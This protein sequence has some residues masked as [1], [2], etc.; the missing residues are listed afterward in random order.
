M[1]NKSKQKVIMPHQ[2]PKVR[3]K[4]FKE[5]C[6]GY[7]YE[8]AK[9]EAD[10]CLNCKHKPCV[11]GC[12]VNVDIPE[13]I[14]CI[15]DDDLEKAYKI[16][17][18]TN[19][20]PAICGRVCPQEKQCEA[21]C[22]MGKIGEPVSIG[23]LERYVSDY[24]RINDTKG[25]KTGDKNGIKIAIVGSGP[26]G[27][28]CAN[29]L[30]LL[31]YDVTIYEALHT[32]GGVLS[33]GIP[34]FRLPRDV[35]K[36]EIDKLKLQGVKIETNVVIGKTLSLDDLFE[37][38]YKAVY[39]A[40]GAGIPRFMG[41]PGE[42]LPQVYCANEFLTRINLMNAHVEK[43]DTP[44]FNAKNVLVVGGGNVA[45][46]AARCA[47]RLGAD[48]TV[49]YRRSEEE[50]PARREEV[51][52]AKEEGINFEFLSNPVK[53]CGDEENNVNSVEYVEMK[54]LDDDGTGRRAVAEKGNGV[55]N[56]KAD[57]VI[58]AI[59]NMPNSIIRESD[60]SIKC[61]SNGC[62]VVDDNTLKTSKPNTYA[63]GDAV[64]GAATVIL[65]MNAGKRAALQIDKDI[66]I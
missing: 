66:N 13:F 44:L 61:K 5:V 3:N 33:Y 18:K 49:M 14:K 54:L 50:M 47:K 52:Q 63:G 32:E 56:I 22:V 51:K 58:M 16:I 23:N 53:I 9:E 45:M 40:S 46:D 38:G 43:F 57:C 8:R 2:D 41:I 17:A 64:T 62:I 36:Y 65:A 26:S 25:N 42:K 37:M 4:N 1:L 59:G 7:D 35:L 10:R 15:L 31:G 55:F 12:P 48:V 39:I 60:K 29:D 6:L 11:S 20:L 28:T 27:L 30:S 34:Q 24:H 21:K 19:A